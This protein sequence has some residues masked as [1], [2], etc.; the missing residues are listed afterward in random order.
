MHVTHIYSSGTRDMLM[1]SASAHV[2]RHKQ[3][4]WSGSIGLF[5]CVSTALKATICALKR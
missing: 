4:R 3:L 5:V 2:F 1:S